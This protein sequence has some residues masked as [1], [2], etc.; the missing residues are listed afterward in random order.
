MLALVC[1]L[2]LI[3]IGFPALGQRVDVRPAALELLPDQVDSNSPAFWR[4]GY[5]SMITSTGMPLISM[6]T[7]PFHW[8]ETT[9]VDLDRQ[10]HLPVWIE[11]AWVDDDG[12]MLL[13]YHHEPSGLCPTSDLTAPKIGAA[14]SLDGGRT[15]QD[16]GIVLESGDPVDC[17]AQNGYFGSGHGDFSVIFN[18]VDGYFYFFFGNYGGDAEGQGIAIARLAHENRYE[19]VGNVHKYYEGSWDEP[20]LGGRVTPALRAK[21]AWQK[22]DT[23]SFWGPS[24]HWNTHLGK[25]VMLLNRACCGPK[26]PQEGI[27]ASFNA[28]LSDP[29]RWSQPSSILKDS[30][31]KPG[32]YPQVLGAGPEETDTVAGRVVRLYIHGVSYWEL[33]FQ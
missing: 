15:I 2:I 4:D 22:S 17:S 18:H 10:E 30:G 14:I 32:Y 1:W 16:L 11:S 28:D 23:D 8:F 33:V 7:S 29:E 20:G 6:G 13:W 27:Y 24:I 9:Q 19:P 3:V 26:W 5:L 12:T 25:Y 31:L 21:K